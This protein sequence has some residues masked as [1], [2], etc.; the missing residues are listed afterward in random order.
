MASVTL[1]ALTND[2]VKTVYGEDTLS[3]M[4]TCDADF[5]SFY[6]GVT[7]TPFS[8][9]KS[10][11]PIINLYGSINTS[12]RGEF[13]AGQVIRVILKAL[14]I[15]QA[16]SIMEGKLAAPSGSESYI[17]LGTKD[18]LKIIKVFCFYSTGTG[19]TWTN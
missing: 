5:T 4:F 18:G 10:A 13:K 6:V 12:G 19:E 16:C 17:N 7:P 9:R 11:Q 8:L 15:E 3:F 2:T 14:D 1:T